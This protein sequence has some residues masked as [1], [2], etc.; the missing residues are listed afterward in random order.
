MGLQ[1]LGIRMGTSLWTARLSAPEL[2]RAKEAILRLEAR[3]EE[4]PPPAHAFLTVTMALAEAVGSGSAPL[5][6]ARSPQ[7]ARSLADRVVRGRSDGGSFV[8]AGVIRSLIEPLLA[9][10][11]PSFRNLLGAISGALIKLESAGQDGRVRG[12]LALPLYW[13]LKSLQW[14]LNGVLQS[15]RTRVPAR[16]ESR[17]SA[18]LA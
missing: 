7:W 11:R 15:S 14:L 3:A 9:G 5:V 12:V 17:A 6:E 1:S 10:D 13:E 2:Q 4:L 8:N 16:S 18:L